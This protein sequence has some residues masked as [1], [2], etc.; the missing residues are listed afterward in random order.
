M[1]ISYSMFV[2]VNNFKFLMLIKKCFVCVYCILVFCIS[3]QLL[4]VIFVCFC[5]LVNVLFYF[6]FLCIC[7]QFPNPAVAQ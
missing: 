7:L 3:C 5:C 4:L 1:L 2:Y 6:L